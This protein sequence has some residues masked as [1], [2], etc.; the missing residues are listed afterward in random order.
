MSGNQCTSLHPQC[1]LQYAIWQIV[2]ASL[3]AE[4]NFTQTSHWHFAVAHEYA[5]LVPEPKWGIISRKASTSQLQIRFPPVRI[6]PSLDHRRS[7]AVRIYQLDSI[8][9]CSATPAACSGC[10]DHADP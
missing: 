6:S 4:R 1:N 10:H 3:E 9:G 2:L 8:G 7:R 5:D